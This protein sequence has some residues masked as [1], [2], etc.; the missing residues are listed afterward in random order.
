MHVFLPDS[1]CLRGLQLRKQMKTTVKGLTRS[2]DF[3][4][5]KYITFYVK[6]LFRSFAQIVHSYNCE[7]T[8]VVSLSGT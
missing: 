1:V 7:R 8:S 2:I 4:P 5:I 3:F 6:S